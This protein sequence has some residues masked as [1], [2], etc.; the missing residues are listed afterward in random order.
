MASELDLTTSVTFHFMLAQS[1]HPSLARSSNNTPNLGLIR[2]AL[3]LPMQG[4]CSTCGKS[5]QFQLPLSDLNHSTDKSKWYVE[6]DP[7]IAP[8]L[9]EID[10]L[11]GDQKYFHF[12][13]INIK[14]RTFGK[15]LQETTAD[16]DTSSHVHTTSMKTE[17]AAVLKQLQTRLNKLFQ[18][19]QA[20][21]FPS[22]NSGIDVNFFNGKTGFPVTTIKKV[23]WIV[24]AWQ[25]LFDSLH[26]THRI[27]EKPLFEESLDVHLD[28]WLHQIK[29][30]PGLRSIAE[31][32]KGVKAAKILDIQQVDS[33][34]QITFSQQASTFDSS[35]V[36]AWID[37]LTKIILRAHYA[38]GTFFAWQ[39]LGDGEYR[40]PTYSAWQMLKDLQVKKSTIKYYQ[41]RKKDAVSQLD[42]DLAAAMESSFR[43]D[44]LGPLA[45]HVANAGLTT[46]NYGRI[47]DTISHRFR[48]GGYGR[49]NK[50]YIEAVEAASAP[51]AHSKKSSWVLV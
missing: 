33:N 49:Y 10:S 36:L 27:A 5:H 28:A 23:S 7:S 24:V 35:A 46:S 25:R 15:T 43:G 21:L 16:T 2:Q 39:F 26:D 17:I 31:L 22:T 30:A 11:G 3:N 1:T 48:N 44:L 37:V 50:A 41:S 47:E 34:G 38:E 19:S 18:G 45:L 12:Y 40:A 42:D 29:K 13:G 20:W 32:L 51:T 8:S 14:S 4:T 9:E 6:A